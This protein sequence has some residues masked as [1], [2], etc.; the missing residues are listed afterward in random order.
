MA[1]P[2]TSEP[3]SAAATAA[4]S[5]SN[6]PGISKLA[7]ARQGFKTKL[8]TKSV[9]GD[10]VEQPPEDVFRLVKY[11]SAV[12][13]LPAYLSV[14]P[15]DGKKY[16]AIIWITGGDC[17]SIGDVW[18]EAEP[19]TD[20]SASVYR[21]SGIVMMF[22]SLRGGND[23]PSAKEGFLGEVDDVIA[24]AD[25]LSKQE[26][27]DP[28]RIYLGGHSTGGTMVLL[29]SECTSRFRAV[30]AFG[31]VDDV[32][33]YGKQLLPCDIKDKKE[34][35]LR[36]PGFWLDSIRSPTFVFEGVERGNL[37]DLLKMAGSPSNLQG[38]GHFFGCPGN[39]FTVLGPVNQMIAEKILKDV[40][41]TCN[42]SFTTEEIKALAKK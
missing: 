40:D 5:P 39:H 26:S 1:E 13:Q 11:D 14:A 31:P 22:P 20:Q 42:L 41:P 24:A 23:N 33:G 28:N 2:A 4:P 9:L 25:F 18:S 6:D 27:V 8:I 37:I 12:G 36:S 32:S 10:P 35:Q 16:P 38:K 30:F 15:N 7:S 34:I 21:K 19:T 29:V 3:S 17:N